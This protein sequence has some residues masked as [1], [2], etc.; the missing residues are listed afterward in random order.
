MACL[1]RKW[2]YGYLLRDISSTILFYKLSDNNKTNKIE[3][4]RIKKNVRRHIQ[5][6][7]QRL[8]GIEKLPIRNIII[9]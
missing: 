5:R 1:F 3:N 9:L 4:Y 8:K 7:V 2:N 6:H